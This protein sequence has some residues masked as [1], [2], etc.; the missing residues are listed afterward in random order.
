MKKS[1]I[2]ASAGILAGATLL[3]CTAPAM[4]HD[5][6][7]FGISIGVPVLPPVAYVAPPVYAPAPYYGAY[8]VQ[9]G[10]P[11]YYYHDRGWHDRG[12]YEHGGHDRGGH[13]FRGRR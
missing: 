5:N 12:W 7:G 10:A 13:D 11:Y 9:V 4:A 6:I 1:L 2:A 8:G 3:L